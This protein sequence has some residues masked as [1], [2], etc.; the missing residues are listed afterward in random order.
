MIALTR[1]IFG[2]AHFTISYQPVSLGMT[3]GIQQPSTGQLC[4]SMCEPR[5][6]CVYGI[7]TSW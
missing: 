6:D 1:R 3:N 5:A 4:I 7:H 2:I